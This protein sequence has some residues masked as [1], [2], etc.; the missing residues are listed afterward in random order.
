MSNENVHPLFQNVL[1]MLNGDAMLS[2]RHQV[3]IL[4]DES[5][6]IMALRD[7]FAASAL[8]GLM[9][10]EGGVDPTTSKGDRDYKDATARVAYEIADAM[11]AERSK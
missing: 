2:E 7:Y 8:S 3:I 6:E 4:P 5:N 11:L 1:A 10:H 9:A